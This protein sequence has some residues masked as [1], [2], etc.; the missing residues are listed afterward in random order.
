MKNVAKKVVA[1]VIALVLCMSLGVTAFAASFTKE[2]GLTVT[3]EKIPGIK[4][5]TITSKD[6]YANGDNIVYQI[7]IENTSEVDIGNVVLKYSIDNGAKLK[8]KEHNIEL[9]KAGATETLTVTTGKITVEESG[10]L[11]SS[12]KSDTTAGMISAGGAGATGLFTT[13]FAGL[14]AVLAVVIIKSKKRVRALAAVVSA[15]VLV[16]TVAGTAVEAYA[17][18][19]HDPSIV[20]DTETGK[21]YIFGSHRAWAESDDLISWKSFSN[22]INSDY[23]EIF[24]EPWGKFAWTQ[25]NNKVD[26]NLWAPDVIYNPTMNKWCMY[27]SVNGD[28]H[29][30]TIVLLTADEAKG[31]YTY[32]DE[33]V[34]SGAEGST[35]GTGES[36]TVKASKVAK[37]GNQKFELDVKITF[38]EAS[39]GLTR[40]EFS[41]MGQVLSAD[42]NY[43]RYT[44]TGFS[45]INCIDPCVNFDED[46]N[47]WMVY[48]SWSAGI[49][50]LKLDVNTGLRDYNYT[51]ETERNVSDAYLGT[52]IAGGHY[53]SGEGGYIFKAGNYWYFFVSYGNLEAS[54]GYNMRVYRS[55]DING[56]YEDMNGKSPIFTSWE[57]SVGYNGNNTPY[58]YNTSRGLKIFGSYKI[59]GSA[60][61]EVAQGHNSCF[62]DEDGKIYLVYHTRFKDSG[63]GHEVRVHQMFINEDGWLVA[64]PYAY[65]GE[66]LPENGYD[67]SQVTG[68]YEFVIHNPSRVYVAGNEDGIMKPVKITL[69]ADGT[70]SGE[71]TGTWTM[72]GAN[73]T[74][75]VDNV[76]YKGVFIEQKNELSTK[77]MTMTFTVA[78][79]NTTAWGVKNPADN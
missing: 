23:K 38:A 18:S 13:F 25:N 49:Y 15:V 7:T 62:V 30:S 9:I 4:I 20:K 66:T 72:S 48:G 71:K 73:V 37:A 60:R 6:N 41:D 40:Y 52:K 24:A 17:V 67:K 19:V 58:K 63:E 12:C 22:N 29:H 43:S 5:T 26:G 33:V 68:T 50:Q 77:D 56:P 51:Y 11:F 74:I 57:G 64:T 70:V 45:R 75:T 27:M 79:K 59:Y 61:V 39:G 76:E 32:V 54:G 34:F 35:S 42:D 53:N 47:L 2:D 1:L 69:N 10:G 28:D 78:G 31:P 44:D 14:F 46:G 65:S 3:T 8:N 16:G 36:M 55:T 21:Y